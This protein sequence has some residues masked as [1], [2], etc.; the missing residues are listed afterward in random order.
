MEQILYQIVAPLI[1]TFLLFSFPQ[2]FVSGVD[3]TVNIEIIFVPAS[4]LMDKDNIM[5]IKQISK[6]K[7]KFSLN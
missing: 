2:F 6:F 3:Q 5:D 4:Y 7:T 1:I